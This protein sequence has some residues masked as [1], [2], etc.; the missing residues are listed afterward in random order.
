MI[1]GNGIFLRKAM[2]LAAG[3]GNRARPMS[4]VRPKPLFPV[5]NRPMIAHTLDRLAAA[6][7][8]DVVVNTHHLGRA[9]S[10]Y[11][12]GAAFRPVI[13][14]IHEEVI[15]GTGGGVK[16][17]GPLL[18]EPFILINSD[19]VTDIDLSV[20]VADF[21]RH[22]PLA[23]L[24]LHDDP[25]F[26]QVAVDRAGMIRGFRGRLADGVGPGD[27][28]TLAFTGIHIV[29]PRVLSWIPEGPGDIID[30]YQNLVEQGRPVRA[31]TVNGHVWWDAGT[32]ERYLAL[33]RDL[34]T[35]RP[36]GPVLKGLAVRVSPGAVLEGWVCLGDGVVVEDGARVSASVLWPGSRV[37]AGVAVKNAV[38]TD[39]AEARRDAVDTVLTANSF[40]GKVGT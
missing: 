7:V 5:L 35:G 4:L 3:F 37:A 30:V 36:Q 11:L 13:H 20:P 31:V 40:E 22:E 2:I 18:D 27:V 38:L 24:V 10:D 28:A 1:S 9:V 21:E 17:A 29:D 16:N 8:E 26:N 6:G 12:S 39:G 15:L 33:H 32:R 14:V 34:L 19:I 23:V 25:R